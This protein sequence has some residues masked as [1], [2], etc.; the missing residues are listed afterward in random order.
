MV[1]QPIDAVLI[2]KP[3]ILAFKEG[4]LNVRISTRVFRTRVRCCKVD[5]STRCL[6][7]MSVLTVLG[8]DGELRV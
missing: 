1:E 8:E 2:D 5:R 4:L 7:C 6:L 3:V